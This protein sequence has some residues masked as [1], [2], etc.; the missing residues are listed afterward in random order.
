MLSVE[1]SIS[2]VRPARG[3]GGDALGLQLGNLVIPYYGLCIVAGV[4]AASLAGWAQTKLYRK[5]FDDLITIAGCAGLG[6][7]L[8]AK[9]LYLA[10]SWNHIDWARFWTDASYLSALMSGGFVF[11]GGVLGALC[12]AWAGGKIF[13]ISIRD[14]VQLA[15]PCIPLGHAFG[16]LGCSLAGCCY[17][18]AY[19]GPGAVTYENSPFA[20]TGVSLFPVQL[21][22]SVLEFVLA[23]LLFLYTDRHIGRPKHGLEIYLGVYA[24]FRFFLEFLRGDERGEYLG[25][26]TS[27][28][29]SLALLMTVGAYAA[30]NICSRRRERRDNG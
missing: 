11:Y 14:Y 26:S 30:W 20:P 1:D 15:A 12:G 22:E 24:A 28:W 13:R 4:S 23:G 8:G 2:S 19:S 16:R 29:L 10:V 18:I 9:L 3:E 21:T 25:L 27:Q 7:I 6:G 17:G 5:S